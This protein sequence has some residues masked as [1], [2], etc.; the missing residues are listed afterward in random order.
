M[1]RTLIIEGMMCEHCEKR[2]KKALEALA[3]VSEA[4]VD[5][6]KG[7]AVV[8]SSMIIPDELLKKAVEDQGYK[9]IDFRP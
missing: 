8:K 1:K 9:V 2:V 5:H 7:S 6:T 3:Y 4:V